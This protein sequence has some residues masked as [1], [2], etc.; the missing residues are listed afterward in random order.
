MAPV[1]IDV[2]DALVLVADLR[3]LRG[4]A[5]EGAQVR[6]VHVAT[7]GGKGRR[8]GLEDAD[9]RVAGGELD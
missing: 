5:A 6:A 4:P 3:T 7:P 9:V 1:Q 8:D 2:R